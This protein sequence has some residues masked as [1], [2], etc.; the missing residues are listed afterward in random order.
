M[1]HTRRI[2]FYDM[3]NEGTKLLLNSENL[4]ESIDV[5]LTRIR[6]ET[7][8]DRIYIFKEKTG[9]H[10]ESLIDQIHEVCADGVE[11]QLENP[12]LSNF[13]WSD[14]TPRWIQQFSESKPI[15][16][17]IV[18]YPEDERAILDPQNI[19]SLLAVPIRFKKRLM[20]FIGFDSVKER[21]DWDENEISLLE[22][23]ASVIG[24]LWQR[25]EK[26][27]ETRLAY[28][29]LQQS[30]AT[31]RV[32]AENLSDAIWIRKMGT[33]E[34]IFQN[35]A[36]ETIYGVSPEEYVS[37]A[38]GFLDFIP[39]EDRP[40]IFAKHQDYLTGKP[41]D[42][43]HRIRRKDGEI[44][45]VSAKGFK[46]HSS[47]GPDLLAGVVRDI[48]ERKRVLSEVTKARD[49]AEELSRLKTALLTSISH[50]FRTPVTG[51]V[52]FAS[53]LRDNLQHDP[54]GLEYLDFI[55]D[56]VTR[57]SNTLEAIME[58]SVI[59]S[60]NV[61]NFPRAIQVN[62][63]LFDH[64]DH[65][66][67]KAHA[68]DLYLQVEW[69]SHDS[70]V[71]DPVIL[72]IILKHLLDNSI[73]FTSVGGIRLLMSV[74]GGELV[75]SVRDTGIGIPKAMMTSI[76]DVFRQGS[77]GMSRMFEGN[78]LG[79]SIVN[80]Y[81]EYLNGSILV[82]SVEGE[83]T[84]FTVRLPVTIVEEAGDTPKSDFKRVLY[85]EDDA[86]IQM[87]VKRSL[88][89][90]DVV[91]Y[92]SAESALEQIV[93]ENFD[94]V[95]LDVNLGGGMNGVSLCKLIRLLPNFKDIPIAAITASGLDP[96]ESYYQAGFTHYLPKPFDSNQLLAFVDDMVRSSLPTH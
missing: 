59:D 26:E 94:A 8:V 78:G 16:G 85:I 83:Y 45:W 14:Y 37:D 75:M 63:T 66:R 9:E 47:N 39:E 34:A 51:I 67:H 70:I 12:D 19:L 55:E 18:D 69:P 80:K 72:K 74:E 48:T 77:E 84:T 20:G 24:A 91:T 86:M 79:L 28:E 11:P 92:F 32:F 89:R 22:S 13:P 27:T 40:R 87:L 44:R 53:L 25:E 50:E 71:V 4:S 5:F 29:Q 7:G 57:L 95:M 1:P 54:K 82:D 52:G 30:E 61:E 41:F 42:E 36:T 58:Y 10:G 38:N 33:G 43:E 60:K 96:E 90:Y 2:R 93:D 31:F 6:E 35:K 3:I 56:S 65:Y 46:I 23:V 62:K 76:F 64:I 88:T 73:K 21:R 68:K 17:H 49:K 81:V 15:V